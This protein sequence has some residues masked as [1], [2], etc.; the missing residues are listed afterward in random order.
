MSLIN[1]FGNAVFELKGLEYL[2]IAL[3]LLIVMALVTR[4]ITLAFKTE[5]IID[6]H[7]R[8]TRARISRALSEIEDSKDTISQVVEA[9]EPCI[10]EASEVASNGKKTRSMSMEERWAAFDKKR[11]MR[12]TA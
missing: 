1:F 9:E 12:N 8:E 7:L 11:S 3:V 4:K 5:R 10:P 6:E 2:L